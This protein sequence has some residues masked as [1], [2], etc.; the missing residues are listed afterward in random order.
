MEIGKSPNKSCLLIK[1]KQVSE[2]IKNEA[3]EEKGKLK[4]NQNQKLGLV[5]AQLKL[6]MMPHFPT[7]FEIQKYYQNK[8]KFND[9]YSINN[10]P[11]I[12]DGA[13]IINL[14]EY[15]LIGTHWIA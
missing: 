5:K 6:L 11:E 2:T 4:L 15:E 7:N 12:N 8:P 14:D 3:K 9:V 10:L 13:Y 1:D